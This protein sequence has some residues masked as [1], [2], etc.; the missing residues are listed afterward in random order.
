MEVVA[1]AAVSVDRQLKS[2]EACV[3]EFGPA[4]KSRRGWQPLRPV[5]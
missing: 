2:S 4:R 5:H 1:R 3:C